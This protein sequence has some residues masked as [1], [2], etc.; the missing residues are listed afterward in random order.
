MQQ[1]NEESLLKEFSQP[2]NLIN[3]SSSTCSN[4]NVNSDKSNSSE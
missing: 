4:N 2:D 1:L 3:Q